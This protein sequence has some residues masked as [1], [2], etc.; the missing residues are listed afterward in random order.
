MYQNVGDETIIEKPMDW[1][2]Y[3]EHDF[4]RRTFGKKV[5]DHKSELYPYPKSVCPFPFYNLMVNVNGDATVCCVDWNKA[6]K[7]GNVFKSSMF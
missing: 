3:N 6:T 1:N 7:I 4:L 5:N 2:G